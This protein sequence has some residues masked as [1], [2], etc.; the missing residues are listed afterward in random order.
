MYN[1]ENAEVTIDGLKVTTN[2]YVAID[3]YGIANISNSTLVGIITNKKTMNL[4][5]V[6]VNS[7]SYNGINN[8]QSGIMNINSG[9]YNVQITN[10]STGALN[11]GT[12]DGNVNTESPLISTNSTSITNTSGTL[13]FYDGTIK[14]TQAVLGS[15]SEI[16]DGYEI[17][18]E[19]K[20]NLEI[21][22][23][24]KEYVAQISSSN[25]KYYTLQEAIDNV[26][27]DNEVVKLLRNIFTLPASSSV[28]VSADKNLIIDLNGFSINQNIDK[29]LIN[30]GTLVL[31]D[32]SA[33]KSEE[34][35]QITYN[36]KF[37]TT[38]DIILENN[39][40]LKIEG[41]I[42]TSTLSVKNLITNNGEMIIEN[43]NMSA[44]E[45]TTNLIENTGGEY[46]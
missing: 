39:G 17:I 16:E 7:N 15:I 33:T 35:E 46:K 45:N 1:S 24:G 19:T 30:N 10:N 29:Y 44:A 26:E 42:F 25:E 8:E 38:K 18:K 31:K 23:L 21:L 36:S 3:N 6:T 27:N 13:N 12:K 37:I 40:T 22:H 5:N 14:G 32:S 28:V 34:S 4:T 20:D 11:I 43:G 2:P 41:G 9:E